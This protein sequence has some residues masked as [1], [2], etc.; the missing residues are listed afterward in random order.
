M[1]RYC[2]DLPYNRVSGLA[3]GALMCSHLCR[4]ERQS[5]PTV[6]WQPVDLQRMLRRDAASGAEPPDDWAEPPT[7]QRAGDNDC[8]HA[9]S[10][11][12]DMLLTRHPTLLSHGCSSD[13]GSCGSYSIVRATACP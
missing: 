4:S 13:T 5:M 1:I 8:N 11:R 3:R 12:M 2:D 10:W 7:P 6:S 9:L